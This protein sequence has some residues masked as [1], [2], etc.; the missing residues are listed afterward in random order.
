MTP[1]C[2]RFIAQLLFI[3][4]RRFLARV[5]L[6]PVNTTGVNSVASE[7]RARRG[8]ARGSWRPHQQVRQRSM[9]RFAPQPEGTGPVFP[10]SSSLVASG[11]SYSALL[12]P[13]TEK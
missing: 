10:S 4:I 8:E 2:I 3:H 9:A 1:K 5:L 7:N 6:G 12:A 11:T 13:R